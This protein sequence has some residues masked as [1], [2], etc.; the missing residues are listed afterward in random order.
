MSKP[1]V[2]LKSAATWDTEYGR[3]TWDYFTDT[4][5]APRYVVIAEWCRR[6]RTRP[7][8]LDL[9]CGDAVLLNY[10]NRSGI[11]AYT[12]VDYSTVAIERA[13]Q[14]LAG[15]RSCI[16]L[17]VSS[18]QEFGWGTRSFDVAVFNESLYYCDDPLL[19]AQR[20]LDALAPQGVLLLS[21][22]L[23]HTD[24]AAAIQEIHTSSILESLT[25][26]DRRREKGWHL[27]AIQRGRSCPE[28]S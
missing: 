3:G 15:D 18:I 26:M 7:S 9:G 28:G 23:R 16:E 27:L 5:Q 4:A 8:I 12:G 14:R 13:R 1:R 25:I 24:L 17:L 6:F 11:T 2:T 22:G 20:Y 21:I 10:L 19:V